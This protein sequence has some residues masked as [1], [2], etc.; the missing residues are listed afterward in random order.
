MRPV[1]GGQIGTQ[2]QLTGDARVLL[3]GHPDLH[4]GG[5]AVSEQLGQRE[6]TADLGVLP[7]SERLDAL[8]RGEVVEEAGVKVVPPA[9]VGDQAPARLDVG[10]TVDV[11][12]PGDHELARGVDPP[13]DGAGEGRPD[14]AHV[15]VLEDE[16]AS[17]QQPVA[18][19]GVGDDVTSFDQGP[20]GILPL[21]K[22][23]GS[24]PSVSVT[25]GSAT[26][27]SSMPTTS[28]SR[29][30]ESS[31]ETTAINARRRRGPA[32]WLQALP[33]AARLGQM[34]NGGR[35]ELRIEAA[36]RLGHAGPAVLRG[37]AGG[38]GAEP[39]ARPAIAEQAG[40][41]LR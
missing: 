20:H 30:S 4:D 32:R 5:A 37:P 3:G 15:V 7:G 2:A 11:D 27:S 21:M 36:H 19:V 12:Q 6:P 17:A 34:L 38:L 31:R 26:R 8:P 13:V 23:S 39:V 10:V 40:Q 22:M 28:A 33:A 9:D 16:D 14:E 29:F 25:F 18:P 41:A 35:L 1:G 24:A